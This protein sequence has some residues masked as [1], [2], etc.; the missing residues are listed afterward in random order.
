MIDVIYDFIPSDHSKQVGLEYYVEELCKGIKLKDEINM[1]DLR[2]ER[3]ESQK[4]FKEISSKVQGVGLDIQNSPEVNSRVEISNEF[5]F[6]DGIN[7]PFLDNYFNIVYFKQIFEY[8]KYL[9]ELLSEVS[10]VLKPDGYFIGSTSH[11]EPFHS[12]IYWNFTPYGFSQLIEE[13]KLKIS[14]MRPR[15]DSL[16]L[17]IRWGLGC[18]IFFKI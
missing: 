2:C 13:A 4:F 15:I 3:G 18:S 16:T 6:Y 11:L 10:R 5:K 12:L 7:I 1:L 9:R 17:I 8:V 14:E